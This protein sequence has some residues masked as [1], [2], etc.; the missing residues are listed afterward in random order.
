MLSFAKFGRPL[1]RIH[2]TLHSIVPF[3]GQSR[4]MSDLTVE[5]TAPNGVRYTQPIGLFVNNE[6]IKSSNGEKIASIS[7]VLVFSF[8]LYAKLLLIDC[9]DESEITSVCA[10]SETDVDKA[11]EAARKAF[12][13][14]AWRDMPGTERGDLLYKLAS[15]IDKNK[16]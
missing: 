5:L 11:V 16:T 4:R 1:L 7:P 9:R 10:A 3:L 8:F 6:W 14:T 15:L 12:K 13:T 2:S